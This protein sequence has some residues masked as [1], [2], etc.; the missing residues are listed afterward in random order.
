MNIAY[1]DNKKISN[2]TKIS[3]YNPSFLYGINCFEGIRAYWNI[4]DSKLLFF[5]LSEHLDRLFNSA[6]YL[7][8]K[9]DTTKDDLLY[10]IRNIIKQESICEDIYMRITF[11][12]NKDTNWSDTE[13]IS[14]LISIRSLKSELGISKPI[15]L[16][17]SSFTRISSKSMP[18]SV[19]AGANYLNSRYA[20]IEAKSKGF[21][22]A[23][24]L[25]S[26]D[27][28]SE[29]TG[30]CIFFIKDDKLYTPSVECDILIGITRNRI[31]QICKKNNIEV[32]E[33]QFSPVMLNTFES[34]FLAGTMI[35]IKPISR[36]ESKE[37]NVN[38]DLLATIINHLNKYVHGVEV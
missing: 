17:I 15:S 4:Q 31:I 25:N 36:I 10:Q 9:F 22:G 29:S 35:E 24:F 13:N 19:K 7:S 11:F 1:L 37:M 14:T 18:P 28:I 34:A 32:I 20:Q 21:D 2:L 3:V 26:K 8:L 5:D 33:S 38:H 6:K 27:Y 16:S 23:L 30:S 12:I